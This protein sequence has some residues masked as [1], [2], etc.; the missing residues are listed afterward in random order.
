MD[1]T[2]PGNSNAGH[3]FENG[4]RG[5]G[6]IGPLLSEEAALGD[7][8][9]FEIYSRGSRPSHA[10]RRSTE[11]AHGA[12]YDHSISSEVMQCH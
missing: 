7:R 5:N 10:V 9:I 4:P 2:L 6:V 12:R 11:L 8:R 1:T 3:S